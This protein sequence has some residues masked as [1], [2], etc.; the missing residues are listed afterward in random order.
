MYTA[1]IKKEE[2]YNL[3]KM[4]NIFTIV[5]LSDLKPFFHE[6]FLRSMDRD[7]L[8][9]ST[10]YRTA[11][12]VANSFQ[13]VETPEADRFMEQ[14]ELDRHG[15]LNGKVQVQGEDHTIR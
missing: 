4:E 15:N 9:I 2:R 13:G 11:S 14:L 7:S 12:E 5:L 1:D 10:V 3:F 6:K 8:L